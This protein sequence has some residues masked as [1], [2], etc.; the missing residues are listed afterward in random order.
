MWRRGVGLEGAG[1]GGG[2]DPGETVGA[3]EGEHR[4][5]GAVCEGDVGGGEDVGGGRDLNRLLL[6][7][8]G[9]AG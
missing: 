3:G 8:L 9:V 5:V 1:V 7:G 6:L 2:G 4:D